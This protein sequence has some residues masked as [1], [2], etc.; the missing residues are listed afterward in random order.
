MP[1]ELTGDYGLLQA[2][3]DPYVNAVHIALLRQ[4][5]ELPPASEARF[6]TLCEQLIRSGPPALTPQGQIVA[7]AG[8]RVDE[9]LLHDEVWAAPEEQLAPWWRQAIR[10]Y[11]RVAP[12]PETPFSREAA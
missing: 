2:V 10:H 8:R 11:S 4:K 12:L 9:S 3:L 7:A 1:P 5:D 6:V